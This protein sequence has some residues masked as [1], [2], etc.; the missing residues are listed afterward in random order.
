VHFYIPLCYEFFR[1]SASSSM[2]AIKELIGDLLVNS[3][4]QTV[5]SNSIT[6]E[7]SSESSGKRVLGLY[8]SAHW[9]P[10]CRDFTPI[11]IEFYNRFKK[12]ETAYS[13]DIVF[14]S[15]DIDEESFLEYLKQMP[16]PAIPYND[17]LL[18]VSCY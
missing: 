9:C 13:L 6:D 12:S 16:W 5:E 17:K 18:K 3:S 4:G 11:L 8:F 2:A 7:L 1:S 14:I 10:P 15:S